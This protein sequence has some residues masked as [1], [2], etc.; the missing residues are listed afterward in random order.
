MKSLCKIAVY[1]QNI[2]LPPNCT[3]QV[4]PKTI[5]TRNVTQL[6]EQEAYT[7]IARFS[8]A[9]KINLE[10]SFDIQ[11]CLVLALRVWNIPQKKTPLAVFQCTPV[12]NITIS[13]PFFIMACISWA[14]SALG[15]TSNLGVFGP[16]TSL[17]LMKHFTGLRLRVVS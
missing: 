16:P 3:F 4:S 13:S 15:A 2:L 7:K 9:P 14:S 8:L 17:L 11:C 10:S 6:C 12:Q 1:S 5:F